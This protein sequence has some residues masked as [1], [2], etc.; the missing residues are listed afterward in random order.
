M[1]RRGYNRGME[2]PDEVGQA[3]YLETMRTRLEVLLADSA[4]QRPLRC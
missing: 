2:Y 4:R 3:D 1:P